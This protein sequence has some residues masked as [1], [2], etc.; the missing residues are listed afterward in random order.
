MFFEFAFRPGESMWPIT[1]VNCVSLTGGSLKVALHEF[2]FTQMNRMMKTLKLL[3][4][5]KRTV[6]RGKIAA[7]LSVEGYRQGGLWL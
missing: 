7:K 3:Y 4:L 5:N 2:R 1:M 6:T